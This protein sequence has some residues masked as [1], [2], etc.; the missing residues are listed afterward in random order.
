MKRQIPVRIRAVVP[1][2][3]GSKVGS[4]SG[5]RFDSDLPVYAASDKDGWLPTPRTGE[6][7]SRRV[8]G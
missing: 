5:C 1:K 4:A 6:N 7:S 8:P 3:T 2:T